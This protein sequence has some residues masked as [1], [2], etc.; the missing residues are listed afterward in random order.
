MSSKRYVL[1]ASVS[2]DNPDAIR[3]VLERLLS[4]ASVTAGPK[5]G[6]FHVQSELTGS[7]ARELN[8]SLLTELRRAEKKTRLRAEWT[9]EGVIERFFDYVPKGQ[10]KA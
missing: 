3:P 6:E 1:R 9:G 10:R 8:R 2:T 5:A 7:S 4:T